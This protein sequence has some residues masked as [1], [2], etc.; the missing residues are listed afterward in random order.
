[1]AK[2]RDSGKGVISEGGGSALGQGLERRGRSSEGRRHG[3]LKSRSLLVAVG[4]KISK[5]DS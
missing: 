2:G 1:M 5:S 4:E 3:G